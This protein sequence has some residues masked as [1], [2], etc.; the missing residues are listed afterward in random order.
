M[1]K[2]RENMGKEKTIMTKRFG[3]LKSVQASNNKGVTKDIR[4]HDAWFKMFWYNTEWLTQWRNSGLRGQATEASKN[5]E[6]AEGSGRG[7]PLPSRLEGMEASS[8]LCVESGM[9]PWLQS[10]FST[11]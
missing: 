10:K 5:N 9:N 1:Y 11:F 2:L 3:L 8:A 7:C 6:S 4:L